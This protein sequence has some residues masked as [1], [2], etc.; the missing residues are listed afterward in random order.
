MNRF[1]TLYDEAA[2]GAPAAPVAP[3]STPA[4]PVAPPPLPE[5]FDYRQY[6]PPEIRDDNSFTKYKT[7]EDLG[8]GLV[9]AQKMIG[10]DPNSLIEVKENISPEERRGVMERFGLPKD[11]SAYKLEPVADVPQWLGTDQPLS[12]GLVAKASELGLFPDQVAGLYQWFAGEMSA[13]SKTHLVET[14]RRDE[15][16][17]GQLKTELGAAFDGKVQAAKHAI[18]KIGGKE[19]LDTINNA[20]L[21]ANPAFIKAMAQVGEMLAEGGTGPDGGKPGGF[22]SG[23]TPAQAAAKGQELLRQALNEKQ[24]SERLRLNTEAQKYFAMAG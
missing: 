1:R 21:G 11:T 13:T 19:F 8:R 10:R 16:A 15:A 23:L 5:G 20:G 9:S 22:Q 4:A 18:D 17:I 12:K 24:P 3:L 14:Q 7:L 6:M 2:G